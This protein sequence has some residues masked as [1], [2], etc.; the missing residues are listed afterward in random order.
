MSFSGDFG[1]LASWRERCGQLAEVPQATAARA[2][3]DLEADVYA[4]FAPEEG[5]GFAPSITTKANGT[6]IVVDSGEPARLPNGLVLP[7]DFG[8]R[9]ASAAAEEFNAR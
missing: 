4:K 5:N 3:A 7:E 9:V 8:E 2:A 1:A 6:S